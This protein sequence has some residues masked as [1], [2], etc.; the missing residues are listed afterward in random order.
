MDLALIPLNE[1]LREVKS[2][3]QTLVIA[4]YEADQDGGHPQVVTRFTGDRFTCYGLAMFV[5]DGLLTELASEQ[6]EVLPL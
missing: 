6:E 4:Y 5:A 1:L 2:R 3:C